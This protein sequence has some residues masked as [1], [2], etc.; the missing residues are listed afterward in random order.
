MHGSI[1]VFMTSNMDGSI[2]V[3]MHKQYGYHKWSKETQTT[4]WVILWSHQTTT[5][6]LYNQFLGPSLSEVENAPVLFTILL[7]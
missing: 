1:K 2:K 7:V 4:K 3:F 5:T 6:Y